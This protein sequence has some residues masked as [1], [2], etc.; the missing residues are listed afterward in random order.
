[1]GI[2]KYLLSQLQLTS[3]NIVVV[4]LVVMATY[5][6]L[7]QLIPNDNILVNTKH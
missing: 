5:N 6:L 2:C 7:G 1:M 4:R 3:Y